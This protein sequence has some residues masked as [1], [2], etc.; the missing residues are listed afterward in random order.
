MTGPGTP[1]AA[2]A[3]AAA[4]PATECDRDYVESDD[5]TI[6]APAATPDKPK[7]FLFDKLA[8]CSFGLGP[9]AQ[10]GLTKNDRT[11]E[12]RSFGWTSAQAA[13]L[14]PWL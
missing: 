3:A 11:L 14:M 8:P 6:S 1:K 12:Y 9:I 7:L 4:A 10:V 5:A 13:S 2:P